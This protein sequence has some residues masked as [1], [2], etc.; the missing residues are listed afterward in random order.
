[1]WMNVHLAL[2][3]VTPMHN[4]ATFLDPS[5]ADATTR[6]AIMATAPNVFLTVRT[7]ILSKI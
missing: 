2:I 5:L 6:M 3:T 1:M 4:V 7:F